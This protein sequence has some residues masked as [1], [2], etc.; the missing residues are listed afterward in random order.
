M[1]FG[2]HNATPQRAQRRSRAHSYYTRGSFYGRSSACVLYDL[3]HSCR[4]EAIEHHSPLWMA[5]VG[6]TDHYLH[7]RTSAEQYSQEVV[8]LAQ[9]VADCPGGEASLGEGG[10][11]A[12]FAQRR[13]AYSSEFRFMLLRHWSLYEAMVHA[14]YTAVRLQTWTE[15]GRRALD[16]L[17]AE[18]GLPLAECR[19]QFRHMSTQATSALQGRLGSVAVAY[20]LGELSFWSFTRQHGAKLNVCASDAVFAV[21]ALLEMPPVAGDTTGGQGA[22]ER[23]LSALGDGHF[24]LL[25]QGIQHAQRLQRA[26]VRTGG[27]ALAGGCVVN[28]GAFRVVNLAQGGA[29]GGADAA[30][31]H[32]PMALL[33]L[34]LFLQ[35]AMLVQ[36]PRGCK[37]LVLAAPDAGSGTGDVDAAMVLIIGINSAP[38]LSDTHGNRFA[39]S[40]RQAAEAVRAPFVHDCFEA[41]VVRLA[42]SHLGPFLEQLQSEMEDLAANA[43]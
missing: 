35:D 15:P 38:K 25:R 37:P 20:G 30:L 11:V 21:T 3:A 4:K 7:G 24:Q 29:A 34:A 41:A 18:T 39:L 22:F 28:A 36:K 23:A 31:L 6:L 26:L 19:Q 32:H 16:R 9:R 43:G 12:A 5:V 10:T 8:E 13:L 14:P 1:P 2:P 33:K 42:A 17:L 27:A 40:F